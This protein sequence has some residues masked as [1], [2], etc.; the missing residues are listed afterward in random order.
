MRVTH[1]CTPCTAPRWRRD[2]A[3]PTDDDDAPGPRTAT[4]QHPNSPIPYDRRFA[5]TSLEG[6]PIYGNNKQTCTALMA[7]TS[8]QLTHAHS[9]DPEYVPL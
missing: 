3:V 7:A 6:D 8:I 2:I 4:H 9:R 5:A 1:L